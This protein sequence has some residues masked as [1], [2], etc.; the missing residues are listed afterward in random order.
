MGFFFFFC[1]F[2]FGN[3]QVISKREKKC[4]LKYTNQSACIEIERLIKHFR[5]GCFTKESG[6]IHGCS[7]AMNMD[8]VLFYL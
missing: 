5:R 3:C 2:C 7:I 6:N 4:F 8:L 1:L